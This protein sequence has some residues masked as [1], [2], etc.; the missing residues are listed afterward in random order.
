MNCGLENDNNASGIYIHVPFCMKKCAYCDFY[1]ITG[2]D[3]IPPYLESVLKEIERTKP[4]PS[5]VDAI[6]FG[7][8]TPSLLEPGQISRFMDALCCRFDIAPFSEIT[9]EANPGTV[10]FEKLA[11][12]RKA[13]VNRLSIGVQSFCDA[14]LLFLSRVYTAAQAVQCFEMAR[15]AGFDNIGLDLIYGLPGQTARQWE[16]DLQVAVELRPEHLSCYMLTYEPGTR[17]TLDLQKGRVKALSEGAVGVLYDVTVDYLAERGLVQYEVSNFST[18]PSTRSRHNQKYWTHAPYI[19]LG[20]AAHSFIRDCRTWNVRSVDGYVRRI[21]TG[22]PPTED[23]EQLDRQ[24]LMMETIY[25]RLRCVDGIDI[26][27]FENRFGIDF[28]TLFGPLLIEY[29]SDKCLEVINGCCRLTRRGMLFADS[30]AS[31]LINLI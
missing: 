23:I 13:G 15:S 29:A 9:L 2:P 21:K 20:P 8:G 11:E 28:N 22:E 12:Y 17:L 10:S 3:K 18:A 14:S 26:T 30:I 1:S 31:R 24:Q 6:Y 27:A 7:G 5:K 16:S 4:P 25:L 19:G